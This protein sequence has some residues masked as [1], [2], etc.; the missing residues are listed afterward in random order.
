[1]HPALLR[2]LW[3]AAGPER[4][5]LVS[6]AV[7][8]ATP[9][10][11]LGGPGP[12][13]ESPPAT[14]PDAART[15]DGTLAGTLGALDDAV[16]TCVAAGIPLADALVMASDTPARVLGSRAVIAVDAPAD[17]V[18]WSSALHPVTTWIG[19]VQQ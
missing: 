9:Q 11:G 7:D 5:C 15:A 8:L 17:L 1:V 4:V 18:L 10:E 12:T 19:G 16:R 2:L 14:R 6:D 3:R 13:E